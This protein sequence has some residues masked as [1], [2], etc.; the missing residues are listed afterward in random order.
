MEEEIWKPVPYPRFCKNYDVS[1]LGR[2]RSYLI[3]RSK[4]RSPTPTILKPRIG[5]RG[6][7]SVVL[8]DNNEYKTFAVHRLVMKAFSPDWNEELQVNHINAIKS[9]NRLV[10]LEM[11][12][13]SENMIHAYKMGLCSYHGSPRRGLPKARV[14]REQVLEIRELSKTVNK[15][16]IA[17]KFQISESQVRRIC[18]ETSWK[19]ID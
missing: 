7:N 17:K 19:H 1:N 16:K 13:R 10:N 8:W 12:T 11:V 14:N 3:R 6:Y 5:K 15:S 2:I 4:R 9:D 18:A